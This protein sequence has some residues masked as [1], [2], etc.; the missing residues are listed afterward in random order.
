MEGQYILIQDETGFEAP[1][2]LHYHFVIGGNDIIIAT[3]VEEDGSL[4]DES[5]ALRT[6]YIDG[7]LEFEPIT[8]EATLNAIEDFMDNM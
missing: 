2:L 8:D 1:F 6:T 4:M 3:R 5:I 7:G